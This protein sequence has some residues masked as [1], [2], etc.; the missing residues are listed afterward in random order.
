MVRSFRTAL[1]RLA[2]LAI[3]VWLGDRA[4]GA[5]F[6][7][8]LTKS[9]F[10]FSVAARGGLPPILLVLGDSRGVNGL[11]A[12]ELEKRTG[13][14]VLNLAYN[15][16][17]TLVAEAVLRDYLGRN[18][19]PRGL[20]LE[21]TN[22]Q[23]NHQLLD[24][25]MCYW[26]FGPA[27]SALADERSPVNRR[28]ARA[29]HLYAYN[30]EIPMRA[31][32]YARRSDQDWIN[33]YRISPAVIEEA[34]AT[35]DF[36][37]G[38]QPENLAALGRIVALARERGIALRLIVVPYLPEYMAHARRW[39][40]WLDAVRAAAGPGARIWDYSSSDRDDS[41]FADRLHLN[42]V[43]GVPFAARLEQDGFLAFDAPERRE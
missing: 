15:G 31:L 27:L 1:F 12:P 28:A 42:D 33:R 36:E 34:R 38:T 16:M 41:H 13:T 40:A 37:F 17:S 21:V 39:D 6:D 2:L 11:Y 10:R 20:V 23:D 4:L 24:G 7:A 18:D 19:Q 3:C 32:F 5:L 25:L 43:G 14:R 8:Q 9:Q 30:G 35:S 26:R 22:V 29:F